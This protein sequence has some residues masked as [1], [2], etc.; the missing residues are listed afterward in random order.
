M[1]MQKLAHR[2]VDMKIKES[3]LNERYPTFIVDGT[4]AAALLPVAAEQEPS[5]EKPQ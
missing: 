5:F 2:T 1:E 4:A 3:F